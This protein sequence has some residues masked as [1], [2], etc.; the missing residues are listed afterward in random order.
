MISPYIYAFF[1]LDFMVSA[2]NPK[3]F[4]HP[5]P[6]C[7]VGFIAVGFGLVFV[8][9]DDVI[10]GLGSFVLIGCVTSQ[11]AFSVHV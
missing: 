11:G 3:D 4:F 10:T 2:R 8:F 9:E 5:P 6:I 7:L 1:C